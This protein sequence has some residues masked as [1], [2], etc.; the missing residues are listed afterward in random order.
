VCGY[1]FALPFGHY[2]F[3]LVVCFGVVFLVCSF[4]EL[5]VLNL[6]YDSI[7]RMWNESIEL[8]E[9]CKKIVGHGSFIYERRISQYKEKMEELRSEIL[10]LEKKEN[11]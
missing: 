5:E 4:T 3:Y 8:N 1:L 10:S 11:K 2:C 6:A 9:D 7:L